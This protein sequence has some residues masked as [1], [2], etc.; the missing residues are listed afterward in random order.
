M[1][2][3]HIHVIPAFVALLGLVFFVLGTKRPKFGLL[4]TPGQIMFFC[5]LLVVLWNVGGRIW[6]W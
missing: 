2:E 5:G 1:G 3:A 6:V 4:V